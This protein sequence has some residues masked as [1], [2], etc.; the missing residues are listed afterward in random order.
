MA[1]PK[2]GPRQRPKEKRTEAEQRRRLERITRLL[3][4]YGIRAASVSSTRVDT[5]LSWLGLSLDED[6]WEDV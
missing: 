5:L 6:F 4:E 3:R 2:V 1:D